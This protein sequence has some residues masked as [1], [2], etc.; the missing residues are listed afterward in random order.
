MIFP[1]TIDELHAEDENEMLNKGKI[2]TI[3][4]QD[5]HK[6]H[7]EIHAKADQNPTTLTH[8]RRHKQLMLLRR[9]RPDLFPP[10]QQPQFP[11]SPAD[12]GSTGNNKPTPATQTQ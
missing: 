4:V 8:V 2:P 3:D 10:E 1:P 6:T 11:T 7:I 9:N 5:D 12:R